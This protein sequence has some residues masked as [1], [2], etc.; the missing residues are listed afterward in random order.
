M[1][2]YPALERWL[3]IPNPNLPRSLDLGASY[4]L[5]LNE[6]TGLY[7]VQLLDMEPASTAR[8]GNHSEGTTRSSDGSS[9]HDTT[10]RTSETAA[11]NATSPSNP[12]PPSSSSPSTPFR[13]SGPNGNLDMGVFIPENDHERFWMSRHPG[14]HAF[15]FHAKRLL[16][17]HWRVTGETRKSLTARI[18][19]SYAMILVWTKETYGYV[20]G[21][22]GAY[23]ILSALRPQ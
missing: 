1:T 6:R 21:P 16:I 20:P 4:E 14:A 10:L 17:R 3:S 9:R 5:R 15:Q 22:D 8:S 23:K 19:V 18:G 13:P 7:S 11:G 2:S 12:C